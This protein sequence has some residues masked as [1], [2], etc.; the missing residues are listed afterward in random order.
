VNPRTLVQIGPGFRE[1]PT[2]NNGFC[3]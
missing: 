1:G 2:Q 3:L